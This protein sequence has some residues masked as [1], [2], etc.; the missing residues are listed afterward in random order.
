MIDFKI[1]LHKQT[2]VKTKDIEITNE[3]LQLTRDF[4]KFAMRTPNCCGL[5]LPQ[6]GI[7]KRICI[8]R[9]EENKGTWIA[10][11][12]ARIT[13]VEEPVRDEK[14]LC[15]SH[16]GKIVLAERYHKV[17]VQ[18][19]DAESNEEVIIEPEGFQ[20]QIWQHEIAHLDGEEEV[21][22]EDPNGIRFTY[23]R[24]EPKIGRNDPCPCG[25]GKKYKRCCL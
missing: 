17:R 1:Q 2:L 12:N 9:D 13:G 7:N 19:W 24:D 5:A 14:E 10:A 25:S 23:K 6:C 22:V 20:A 3:T 21:L 16:P 11:I 15:L 18:Y 8:V 4:K